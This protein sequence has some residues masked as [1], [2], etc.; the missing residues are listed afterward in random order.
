MRLNLFL[1]CFCEFCRC[2]SVVVLGWSIASSTK[3]LTG[4]IHSIRLFSS[5][6]K[7]DISSQ[8]IIGVFD[9]ANSF[10][11]AWLN[12][13]VGSLPR[14]KLNGTILFIYPF[15]IIYFI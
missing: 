3:G 15:D 11:L 14:F 5:Y 12:S 4:D 13:R 6:L 2:L 8:N 10:N 9:N 1:P 7:S